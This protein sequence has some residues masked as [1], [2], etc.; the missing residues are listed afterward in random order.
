[1]VRLIM[2][3][4]FGCVEEGSVSLMTEGIMECE[5]DIGVSIDAI[6]EVGKDLKQVLIFLSSTGITAYN[7]MFGVFQVSLAKGAKG[8]IPFFP[9]MH[10]FRCGRKPADKLSEP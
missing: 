10:L 6:Q 2:L 5:N 7:N 8:R 9:F 1:M 3:E 4:D